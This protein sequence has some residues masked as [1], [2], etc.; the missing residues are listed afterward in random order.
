MSRQVSKKMFLKHGFIGFGNMAKAIF[1]GLSQSIPKE[2]FRYFSKT[3]RHREIDSVNSI[4]DLINWSD[5]L[6]FGFKPQN[7]EEI[8]QELKTQEKQIS[9]KNKCIVTMLA[10]KKTN[11][12]LQNIKDISAVIRIMPNLAIT[13]QKSVTG[14]YSVIQND[15]NK[16]STNQKIANNIAMIKSDLEKLGTVLEIEENQF[17]LFTAIFGSGPAFLLE[18]I[19]TFE[20]QANQIVEL[21]KLKSTMAMFVE[22]TLD[23]YKQ[24]DSQK[25]TELVKNITSKGGTTEA[26]LKIFHQNKIGESMGEVFQVATNRSIEL[27]SQKKKKKILVT[28]FDVSSDHN[29]A[30]IHDNLVAKYPNHFEFSVY[31]GEKI[32]K[33]NVTF[34][35]D[36]VT[37]SKIGF[38]ESVS[39]ILPSLFFLR[40][41]KKHLK[42]NKYDLVLCLDGQ[43]F[44]L[45]IGKMAKKLNLKTMYYF[46][47]LLFVMHVAKKK[48]KYF[49]KFL[50]PF[51]KNHEIYQQHQLSSQYVGHPFSN[52]K[53]VKKSKTSKKIIGIF[54][55]S[56][57][58]EIKKM[59]PLFLEIVNKLLKNQSL[60]N[61]QFKLALSH[62]DYLLAIKNNLKKYGLEDKVE[63]VT[64]KIDN[65]ISRCY[66]MICCSGS[67]TLKAS[68][69]HVP[70][71]IC[72][73][74]SKLTYW[75][76]KKIVKV[77]HIGML[78]ILSDKE[79][80]PEFINENVN[81]IYNTIFEK[82]TDEKSYQ[83]T[84]K[85]LITEVKKLK[86]K[87]PFSTAAEEIYRMVG[88]K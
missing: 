73:R 54:P 20:D 86:D 34:L 28:I 36:T 43:G 65:F 27:G 3:N 11:L 21:Q 79:I 13:Y 53:A 74:I 33:R 77:N 32:K 59:T 83:K 75:I 70:H 24:N 17:D 16:K 52:Y 66:F 61:Y 7:L 63:I 37:K 40:K 69:F 10:G 9:F 64:E 26:G 71:V 81:S 31:A 56:R 5:V 72:Y 18:V 78:N 85:E 1:K 35:G 67:V 15:E 6:W 25:I 45:E 49:D 62:A 30:M 68:F 47:P 12:I 14:L 48:L 80:I 23:Y 41:V 22:G 38:L 50:C 44:N 42:K 55:G 88:E 4:S 39:S 51:K 84:K 2:N 8:L 76:G 46:P 29:F 58:Q 19:K 87:D 60:E 82:L 57:W